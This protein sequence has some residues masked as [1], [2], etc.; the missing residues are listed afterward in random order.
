MSTSAHVVAWICFVLGAL[1]LVA[2]MV[3]GLSLSSIRKTT[4]AV[5][6]KEVSDKIKDASQTVEQLKKEA[7]ASAQKPARDEDAAKAMS[8]NANDVM[9]VLGEIDGIIGALPE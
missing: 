2:G 8:N 6:A 1:I 5:T 3:I 7:V 9:S 4:Q